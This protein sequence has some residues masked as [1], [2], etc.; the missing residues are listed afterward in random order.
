M[1]RRGRRTSAGELTT[2]YWRDIPAQI[3]ARRGSDKEK[4][5]LTK[6][7]QLA[8]DRAAGVAGLTNAHDYVEQ[9]RRSSV[10]IDG[11]LDAEVRTQ[12]ERLENEY[13]RLRLQQL[14]RQG[15]SET[16]VPTASRASS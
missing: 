5:L 14:V 3:T 13:P 2:I 16:T 1:T 7:F 15:G 10:G 6:R 4:A 12:A 11:E 9:W 8:I